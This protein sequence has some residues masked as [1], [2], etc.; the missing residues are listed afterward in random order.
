MN[1]PTP[2]PSDVPQ[3]YS[4]LQEEDPTSA[5]FEYID[6]RFGANCQHM[7]LKRNSLV[8]LQ[9]S[10]IQYLYLIK[11]GE[12]TLTRCSLDGGETLLSV[13][14]TGSF[15]GE[16]ALLSGASVT[17]SANA[18]K[19][20]IVMLVPRRK[21]LSLLEDPQICRWLL[22]TT[23][24]RCADAWSQME[25]IGCTYA[26]EKVRS[27]LRWLSGRIG[28]ETHRGVRIDL[29]QTQLARMI[30]CAR[31]TLSREVNELKRMSAV[32]ICYDNGKKS[33]FVLD[34]ESLSESF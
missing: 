27:G 23:A 12:I 33:F 22:K 32:D 5:L 18:T 17:F 1:M 6:M 30:G 31:E 24:G 25:V 19:H 4:P 7:E 14:G 10:D 3:S 11:K 29:N 26:R 9:G 16:S 20:S 2:L 28:V 8:C 34:P 13:L 15:F 21:F